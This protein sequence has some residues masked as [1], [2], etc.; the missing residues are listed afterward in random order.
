M[1]RFQALI[2]LFALLAATGSVLAQAATDPMPACCA[3]GLCPMHRSQNSH[4]AS[5]AK[6]DCN[7]AGSMNCC[8]ANC[9]GSQ[10]AEKAALFPVLEAVLQAGQDLP[11]LKNTRGTIAPVFAVGFSGFAFSPEQPPR[12]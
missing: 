7:A 6:S 10:G 5:K 9:S 2:L 12:Q 4:S 1:R 3:N 11:V 8:C